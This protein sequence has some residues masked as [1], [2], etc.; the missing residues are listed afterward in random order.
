MYLSL[1][2]MQRRGVYSLLTCSVKHLTTLTYRLQKEKT[3][4]LLVCN[5]L[6][7]QNNRDNELMSFN[8]VLR[9]SLSVE[10]TTPAFCETCKKFTPTNQYAQVTELPQILSINCGLTNEKEMDF[11]RKQMSRNTGNSGSGTDSNASQP[12]SN[13]PI[14]PC[15]YGQNCSRVGCHFAHSDRKSPNITN[16]TVPTAVSTSSSRSTT[17]FPME[18]TMD[19]DNTNNLRIDLNADAENAPNAENAPETAAND[20]K[21]DAST[22]VDSLNDLKLSTE[23]ETKTDESASKETLATASTRKL[24]KLS[25]VVCQIINGN[26]KNLVALIHVGGQYLKARNSR[27]MGNSKTRISR[28]ET[29]N[30]ESNESKANEWEGGQWYIFN[31][32]R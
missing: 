4:I 24:Y 19:I 17:W 23:N 21:V 15:R 9:N 26:Q 12:K 7:G 28:E 5:L 10:K 1:S 30:D 32:F 11:L 29:N 8:Q 6:L 14:K 31:D 20:D 13:T 3:N 22:V 2:E 27:F 16:A 18:F 25:A